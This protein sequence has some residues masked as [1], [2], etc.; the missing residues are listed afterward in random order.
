MPTKINKNHGI[1]FKDNY[2][3]LKTTIIVNSR[4]TFVFALKKCNCVAFR[5]QNKK[6]MTKKIIILY[7]IPK[8]R[9]AS[10]MQKQ[11]II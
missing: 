2:C 8:Q 4:K 6:E 10:Y 7:C 1:N 3:Q 9:A 11:N 5:E